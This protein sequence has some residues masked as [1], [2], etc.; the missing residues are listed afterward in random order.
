MAIISE[1][2]KIPKNATDLPVFILIYIFAFHNNIEFLPI[3]YFIVPFQNVPYSFQNM[4]H[5]MEWDRMDCAAL[6]RE[7]VAVQTHT[8]SLPT[9]ALICTA[10][11]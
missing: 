2:T 11:R 5:R 10:R 1:G 4:H 3:D 8:R 9:Q 6:E 7:W